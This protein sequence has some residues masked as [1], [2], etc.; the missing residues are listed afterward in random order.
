M[1]NLQEMTDNEF[2][3]WLHDEFWKAAMDDADMLE[4]TL[5]PNGVPP[6]DP[7]DWENFVKIARTKGIILN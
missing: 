1:K 7:K 3:T 2:D 4:K 5:F 6:A